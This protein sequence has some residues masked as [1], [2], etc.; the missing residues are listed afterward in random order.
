MIYRFADCVID[1][2]L[3]RFYRDGKAVDMTPKMFAVLV[4]LLEKRGELIKRETLLQQHWPGLYIA[5]GTLTTEIGRLRRAIGHSKHCKLI[6]T[7]HRKGYRFVAEAVSAQP[8]HES[9]PAA[10]ETVAEPV[11]FTEPD[12]ESAALVIPQQ[13]LRQSAGIASAPASTAALTASAPAASELADSVPPACAKISP[14]TFP[15]AAERRQLT[16]LCCQR[17]SENDDSDDVDA[18]YRCQQQLRQWCL[19]CFTPLGGHLAQSLADTLMFYFGYPQAFEDNAQRALLAALRL[20]EQL[21]PATQHSA[22]ASTLQVRISIHSG[23]A[24][25]EPVNFCNCVDAAGF[26]PDAD[27][28]VAPV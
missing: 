3:G 27:P 28:G 22:T 2:R 15:V 11:T 5:D 13:N 18:Q 25:T 7:V 16:V 23:P 6:E 26:R 8:D 9:A 21:Q 4:H 1:T 20:L 19:E 12:S 14:K 24:V 10:T 17:V